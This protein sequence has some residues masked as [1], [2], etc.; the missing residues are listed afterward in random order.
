MGTAILIV[1]PDADGFSELRGEMSSQKDFGVTLAGSG[2]EALNLIKNKSFHM[3]VADEN[4]GDMSGLEFAEKLVHL[5]PLVNCALVNSL[6]PREFHEASEG[7]GI[8]AQLSP[9]PDKE[10]A[11][12]LVEKYFEIIGLNRA[13]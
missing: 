7:L 10:A 1:T 11:K 8:L 3:V 6:A 13:Y 2:T 5:N 12:E 9:R 4:L